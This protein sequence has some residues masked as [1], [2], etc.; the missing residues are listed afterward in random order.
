MTTEIKIGHKVKDATTGMEGIVTGHI[1]MLSGTR[2]LIVQPRSADGSAISDAWN[3]DVDS[4]DYVDEG[5]VE[6]SG[7]PNDHDIKLGEEARDRVSGV[8]GTVTTLT[9]FLN[10]CVYATIQP[11]A[12]KGATEKP[13]TLFVSTTVVERV[14]MGLSEAAKQPVKPAKTGGP[15]TR[16]SYIR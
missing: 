7:T 4:L 6:R 10:G 12:K 5:I 16:A 15:S 8:T 9:T 13:E 14:G 3:I 11:K 1:H 2:Q